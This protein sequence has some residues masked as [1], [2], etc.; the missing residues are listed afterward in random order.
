MYKAILSGGF[1]HLLC[2]IHILLAM[3]TMDL[4]C[5]PVAE[6][7]EKI[8]NEKDDDKRS[9]N[10]QVPSSC[11]GALTPIQERIDPP[12]VAIRRSRG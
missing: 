5:D 4:L 7:V 12:L 1:G 11:H 2:S 3:V 8:L 10:A 6:Q 9:T